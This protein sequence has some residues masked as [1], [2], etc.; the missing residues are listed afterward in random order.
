MEP[1][2]LPE[3]TLRKFA[4][5]VDPITA[6]R[7][8]GGPENGSQIVGWVRENDRSARWVEAIPEW[9]SRDGKSSTPAEPEHIALRT[10]RGMKD[11][12]VGSW[13]YLDDAGDFRSMTDAEIGKDYSEV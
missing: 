12:L 11:I 1:T 8:T 3:L 6:V 10:P 9:T 2:E 5:K 13:I 4:K 7:F